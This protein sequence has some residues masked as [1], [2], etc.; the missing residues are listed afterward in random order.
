[1]IAADHA[2]PD[3]RPPGA[4]ALTRA[5]VTRPCGAHTV[6]SVREWSHEDLSRYLD[7]AM[8]AEGVRNDA[9]L[10]RL[11]GVKQTQISNWR[12]GLN[13]P[14]ADLLDRIARTLNVPAVTLYALAGRMPSDDGAAPD[15]TVL[16][17]E[18]RDLIALWTDPGLGDSDRETL[19]IN[20]RT[21]VRGMRALLPPAPSATKRRTNTGRAS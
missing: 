19:L 16:P 11:S 9:E 14:T 2:P 8:R 10:S 13:R 18:L 3:N 1:M 15:L 12:R 17:P 21:I 20:I 7:K 5:G 6:S 4:P